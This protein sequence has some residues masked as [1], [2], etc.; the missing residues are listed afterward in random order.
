MKELGGKVVAS[1]K[2]RE[3]LRLTKDGKEVMEMLT[4]TYDIDPSRLAYFGA[5]PRRIN[6]DG[7][8]ERLHG[9]VVL[10]STSKETTGRSF[11][12]LTAKRMPRPSA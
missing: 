7:E 4:G 3:T 12:E 10:I 8:G 9:G 5:G 2:S 1:E 11:G 6:D